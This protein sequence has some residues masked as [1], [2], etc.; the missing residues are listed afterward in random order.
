M[1][2]NWVFR[3]QDAISS[4]RACGSVSGCDVESGL[5]GVRLQVGVE[6]LRFLQ[7]PTPLDLIL[8]DV[9]RLLGKLMKCKTSGI[10]PLRPLPPALK[11]TISVEAASAS[12]RCS[13]QPLSIPGTSLDSI[14][15][16][17]KDHIAP[18]AAKFN[19]PSGL[20]VTMKL[21][22]QLQLPLL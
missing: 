6:A 16:R 10:F 3:C 9:L 19:F 20:V 12:K 7:V 8:T 22:R 13:E 11:R 1:A 15:Q 4:D 18:L 17:L 5:E 21:Q 14:H 2:L